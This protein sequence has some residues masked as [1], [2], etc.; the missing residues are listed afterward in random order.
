MEWN[1]IGF[2]FFLKGVRQSLVLYE[3]SSTGADE[4]KE[5]KY[6]LEGKTSSSSSVW[7]HGNTFFLFFPV[8]GCCS[9]LCMRREYRPG[10]NLPTPLLS[11]IQSAAVRWYYLTSSISRGYPQVPLATRPLLLPL[12]SR[13][14]SRACQMREFVR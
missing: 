2:P 10:L 5:E 7:A 4:V 11:Y 14:E 1:G 8:R 9:V 12:R 3:Y 6:S 13:T